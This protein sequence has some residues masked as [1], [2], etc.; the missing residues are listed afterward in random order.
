MELLVRTKK[1]FAPDFD[2][3]GLP[4]YPAFKRFVFNRLRAKE[5]PAH[6]FRLTLDPLDSLELSIFRSYEPFETALL[7]DAIKPGMRIADIGANIGYYSLLFSKL[8]GDTGFV[9]AFEPD[10]ANFALLQKNLAQNGR[11]N[12]IAFNRGASSQSGNSFLYLSNE[13]LGDHQAYDA[14]EGRHKIDIAMVRVDE[15][16]EAPLHLVKMDIQGFE[17]HALQGLPKIIQASPD[18]IILTEFWPAGL[19]RAGSNAREF[20]ALLRSYQFEIFY[21][22]EYANRLEV[23]DDE[24]PIASL[25]PGTRDTHESILSPKTS[26]PLKG[27][28]NSVA[29]APATSAKNSR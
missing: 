26:L 12:V 6:G 29:Q 11:E 25:F 28:R 8:T 14:G 1:R 22:N 18:L 21:I 17:F 5:V 24:L 9:F 19:K 20:L 4:L 27:S 7:T 3:E 23:A 13:N 2:L 15:V 16:V 10:P